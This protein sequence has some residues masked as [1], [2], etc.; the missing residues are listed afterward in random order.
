MSVVNVGQMAPD[1]VLQTVEGEAVPLS[2]AW[3]QGGSALLIFL[4]HLA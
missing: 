3:R 2:A 4:R 1:A